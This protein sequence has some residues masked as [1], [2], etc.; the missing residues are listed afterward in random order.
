[1]SVASE[2]VRSVSSARS[3]L[4]LAHPREIVVSRQYSLIGGSRTGLGFFITAMATMPAATLGRS[5][6][7]DLRH[8][9]SS[10]AFAT[11]LGAIAASSRLHASRLDPVP[12]SG[13]DDDRN[14][15]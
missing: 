4:A 14:H 8:S 6:R 7:P 9:L 13:T 3:V 12:H 5:V 1:M 10:V 15:N 2:T 11:I